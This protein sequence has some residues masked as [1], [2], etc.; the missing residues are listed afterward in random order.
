M[1][2]AA[3]TEIPGNDDPA[4]AALSSMKIVRNWQR[5][6]AG[7]FGGGRTGRPAGAAPRGTGGAIALLIA[8]FWGATGFYMVDAAERAVVLRFGLCSR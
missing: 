3:E 7:I 8:A 5:R 1:N 6:L 4:R 2:R